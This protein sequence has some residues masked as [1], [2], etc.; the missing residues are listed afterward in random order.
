MNNEIPVLADKSQ[1]IPISSSVKLAI[2]LPTARW[3]PMAQAVIASLVGVANEEVA[4]LIADNSENE[5]KRVFLQKICDINPHIIAVTHE[6]NIGVIA[7]ILYL[8]DWCKAIPFCA[9]MADDDWM[10]PTYHAN[11]FQLL[12]NNPRATGAEVGNTFVDMHGDGRFENIS[13]VAMQGQ[14]PIERIRQWNGTLLR[15]TMYNVSLRSSLEKAIHFYRTT[16]I[17]GYML[18]EDLWELSRLSVGDFISERASGCFVHYPAHE[19]RTGNST[20][21]LYNLL[22]KEAGLQF[23]FVYF[24]ALS[25]AIQCAIFL[26]GNLSPIVEPKQKKMCGQHV[27]RHIFLDSFLPLFSSDYSRDM[28]TTLFAAHPEAMAGFLKFTQPPFINNPVFDYDGYEI[29]EW[30]I[31]IIKVFETQLPTNESLLSEQ[32]SFFVDKIM[33]K[34]W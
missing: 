9:I 28:I 5:E 17:N 13:Q 18:A 29:I 14:T 21:R 2:L 12:S 25:T 8:F 16:P 4:V 23:S 24:A 6:K 20:E 30:F 22:Y 7:N 19:S 31:E 11:A 3:T 27:F 33:D 34:A 15:I 32:F 10:S 26:M 1:F